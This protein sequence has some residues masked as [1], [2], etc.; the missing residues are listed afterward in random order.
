MMNGF[1]KYLYALVGIFMS[2]FSFGQNKIAMNGLEDTPS[3]KTNIHNK[4]IYNQVKYFPN[5]TELSI[6]IIDSG[7]V[8]YLGIKRLDDTIRF[9][10]NSQDVFE[11]GSLSKVFTATL[12]ANISLENILNLDDNIQDY[13]GFDIKTSDTITFKTLANHTS[14][15]PRLPSNLNMFMADRNNPYSAYNSKD[16]IEYLTNK[17]ELKSKPGNKYDYSNLGAGILGYA[18][19]EI[20]KSTYED[21]L[22][23]KI[24]SKY[25]MTNSTTQK[26][27]I[28]NH[29][30]K[31]LNPS[32]E[33]TPNWDFDVLAGGGAILS[34]IEDL[35]AFGLAHFE[36]T[37]EEL[38]ITQ[39]PTFVVNEKMSLGLGW[40]ILKGPKGGDIL[41]HNGGTGGYSSS[42]ALDIAKKN[43][44][45]I[46]SNVS[47]FHKNKGNLDQLCFELIKW[48]EEK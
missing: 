46:L 40:H 35:T 36:T 10:I 16:L 34:N 33:V 27:K 12:L 25:H 26:D 18:L 44:I 30:V 11:I 39:I 48:L 9:A 15:L 4:L 20:K 24:F 32:G 28:K 29:L 1:K 17:V 38:L 47:A 21:L 42:M 3:V 2:S 5:N 22:H 8:Q 31:G 6:A 23:E 41:W 7:M 43:G 37:N 14:G 45:I 19:A 13:L